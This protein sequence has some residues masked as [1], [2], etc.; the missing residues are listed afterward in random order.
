MKSLGFLWFVLAASLGGC[1]EKPPPA[2]P[3]APPPVAFLGPIDI[4]QV[5]LGGDDLC[6]RLRTGRVMCRK[7]WRGLG[8][9][10]HSFTTVAGI[11][12]A[13]D[14]SL[15]GHH[16]C[17][18]TVQGGVACWGRNAFGEVGAGPDPTRAPLDVAGVPQG[19]LE[20]RLDDA[21]SCARM[22][23]GTVRCWGSVATLTHLP[24]T[25]VSGLTKV[26]GIAVG[27]G[28]LCA[29]LLDGTVRCSRGGTPFEIAGLDHVLEIAL[30]NVEGC[31]R[32]TDGSIACW[33][34]DNSS[35]TSDKPIA[36]KNAGKNHDGTPATTPM[37]GLGPVAQ[38][39]TGRYH[40]CAR[41]VDGS[42]W[43]WGSNDY[44]QLGDGS[45]ASHATP[46]KVKGIDDAVELAAGG[47]RTCARRASGAVYCWGRDLLDDPL[48]HA[49]TG[50]QAPPGPPGE[51]D[52]L[53]PELLRVPEHAD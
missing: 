4:A 5:A 11:N 31:A 27:H 21:R 6:I 18:R 29:R 30:S 10:P 42:I 9:T 28:Q 23:D 3:V 43:C 37:N 38:L 36:I 12:D 26:M 1:V 52:S 48:F 45:R 8:T 13:T 20:I 47:D 7:D 44:G 25:Q 49:L 33:P 14:V 34:L 53:R 17:V 19:A 22:V 15:G 51:F 35:D 32:K 40:T 16:A 2:A 41:N 50:K 46:A 39:A 24:P